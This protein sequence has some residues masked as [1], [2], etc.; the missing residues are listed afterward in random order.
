MLTPL[1]LTVLTVAAPTF[2]IACAS[3]LALPMLQWKEKGRN[4]SSAPSASSAEATAD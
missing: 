2:L 1:S 3:S 4:R